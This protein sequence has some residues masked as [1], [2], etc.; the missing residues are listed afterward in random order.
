MKTCKMYKSKITNDEIIKLPLYSFEGEVI[1]VDDFEKLDQAISCLKNETILGF[2]T[3]TK[4]CFTKGRA[5][6]N[7]VALLQL[8]TSD[9]AFLFRLNKIGLP[10]ELRDILAD[11]K[12]CKI[13]VAIRDDIK[14]LRQ[15]NDF[16][17][18]NFID[19]STY[20]NQFD[21][22]DNGLRKLVAIVLNV[23][24]SKSQQLSNWES[25]ELTEP[26]QRYAATDAWACYEIFCRLKN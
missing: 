12:I 5:N 13:G 14:E 20:V 19:L 24:I 2:D 15:L 11:A 16:R 23:R 25:T 26:Q 6:L 7:K 17:A 21:I 8:S 9:K 22:E 1:I 3:E 4:P 10:N 18:N